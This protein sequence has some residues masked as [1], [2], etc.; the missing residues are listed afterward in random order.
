MKISKVC[1][2][3]LGTIGLAAA[4]YI[5]KRGLKVQGYDI[6]NAAVR[7]ASRR[8]IRASTNIDN[9]NAE[10]IVICVTTS[11]KDGKSVIDPVAD[12]VRRIAGLRKE[13]KTFVSIESTMPPGACRDLFSQFLGPSFLLVHVPQR[14]W[15]GDTRNHGIKQLRVIGALD[16]ASLDAGT[17]FYEKQLQIPLHRAGSLEIAEASKVLENAYRYVQIAF[18]EEA[19]M[20]LDESG[21]DFEATR[22][23]SNTKWN[24]EIPEAREGIGGYCLP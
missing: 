19:K 20:I 8:G 5:A 17:E 10:A 6:T 15:A 18:A 11:V 3:G 1:V 12:V 16:D 21:I 24:V 2:V 7:R 22:E 9:L 14:F 13:R 23:S 4:V